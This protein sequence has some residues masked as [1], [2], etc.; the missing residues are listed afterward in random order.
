MV[1]GGRGG[2]SHITGMLRESPTTPPRPDDD[3][4]VD[5]AG[6]A[7]TPA[8]ID[9]LPPRLAAIAR[10]YLPDAEP[11]GGEADDAGASE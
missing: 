8:E 1:I 6:V 5:A 11:E 9:A 3:R 7:L 10:R 2:P 4:T